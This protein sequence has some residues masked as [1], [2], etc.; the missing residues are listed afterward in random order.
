M[1][2]FDWKNGY[3]VSVGK[4]NDDHRQLMAIMN[5]LFQSNEQGASY[6]QLRKIIDELA[7]YTVE[8]F[9]RE[10]AYMAQVGFPDTETHKLIHKDLLTKFNGHVA[11]YA[12]TKGKVP[13]KFFLFLKNWLSAHIQGID[14]KYGEYVRARK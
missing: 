13:E 2:F 14:I 10:E 4:M 11:S 7:S 3:D 9:T 8:H 5:R 6:E 1:G 12:Q